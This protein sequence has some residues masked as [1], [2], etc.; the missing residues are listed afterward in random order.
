MSATG[1]SIQRFVAGKTLAIVGV[2]AAGRGFGNAA[3]TELKKRGYRVLPV[4]PTAAAI[5]GD[6][7]WPSVAELPERVERLLVCV[8]PDRADPV[9]RQAAAAGVRQVWFQLG[10]ESPAALEACAQLGVEAV[11]GQCILMFAEPVGSFHKF[12]RLVWKLIGRL[13]G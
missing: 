6:P 5:Q 9:V 4:H 1:A 3:Y 11:Q 13:P 7:C 2:S 12:H 8:K 10:A